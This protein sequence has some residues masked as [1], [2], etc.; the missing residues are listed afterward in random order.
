ML[1]RTWKPVAA[2]VFCLASL[3]L[4]MTLAAGPAV[5]DKDD[6][7]KHPHIRAAIEELREARK[8]L[9]EGDHD[10]E[11]HRKEAIEAVDV[12]IKQLEICLKVDKK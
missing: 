2:V 11:G 10:F 9:K 8:D 3:G 1:V 5:A 7:E 4:L 12:A 6:K